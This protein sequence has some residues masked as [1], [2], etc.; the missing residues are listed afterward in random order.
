MPVIPNIKEVSIKQDN[1]S[2]TFCK[3]NKSDFSS[4]IER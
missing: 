2:R 1:A 4:I 3:E